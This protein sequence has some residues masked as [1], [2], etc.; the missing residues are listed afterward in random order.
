MYL[1]L[2][3]GTIQSNQDLHKDEWTPF[4]LREILENHDWMKESE[5]SWF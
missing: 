2:L 1:G 3:Q 5:L 4:G